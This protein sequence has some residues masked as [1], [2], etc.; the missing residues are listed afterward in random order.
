MRFVL[1]VLCCPGPGLTTHKPVYLIRF[2]PF[3]KYDPTLSDS[4]ASAEKPYIL[5]STSMVP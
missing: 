5:F 3:E 2:D 4:I 1:L